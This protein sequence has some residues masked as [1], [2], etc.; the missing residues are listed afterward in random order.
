MEEKEKNILPTEGADAPPAN[1]HLE[2]SSSVPGNGDTPVNL[3]GWLKLINQPP[4]GSN[5]NAQLRRMCQVLYPENELPH[6]GRFGKLAKQV[7]GPARLAQLIWE[8][9]GKRP[10]GDVLSYIEAAEKARRRNGAN[11][12]NEPRGRPIIF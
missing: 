2:N 3:E 12:R 11:Q 10:V 6:F 5:V 4:P 9:A 1:G 7:G 8:A